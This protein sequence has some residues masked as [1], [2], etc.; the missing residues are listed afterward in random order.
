MNK[1]SI[2]KIFKSPLDKLFGLIGNELSQTFSNR[3]LEYQVE[4]YKRNYYCKTILH[5]STPKALPEFYEPLYI[6]KPRSDNRIETTSTTKLFENRN[7][8]TLIGNAGSGKST[9][10]KYLF[11]NCFKEKYKIPIK[12]ELRYLNEHEGRLNDYIFNEIFHFQKLG[13]SDEIIDRMLSSGEFI[14]FFDGYDEISSKIKEKTTKDIDSFVMKYSKNN[15]I[16]T[17]RPYTNIETL[18]LFENYQVSE[19]N[20]EEIAFFV[21][22]QLPSQEAELAEKIINTIH[23]NENKSY[24]AYLSNPLLLSMFVLTYQSYSNVPQKRSD[25]YEQVFNALFSSHDS[26]SKLGFEHEKLSGL[27]KEQFEEVLQLFSFLSFFDE[28]FIF[29]R[30]YLFEK[31]TLIKSKKNHLIF[32]NSKIINDLQVAIAIL[33]EE[34]VNY[35]FPHRS[36]QE[37]FAAKYISKLDN[38]NKERIYKKIL[39]HIIGLQ[40]RQFSDRFHFYTLLCEIDEKNVI[41][42]AIIPYL[43]SYK[44]T[45]NTLNPELLHQ[46]FFEIKRLYFSFQNILEISDIIDF[47]VK[48]QKNH[49][50]YLLRNFLLKFIPKMISQGEK[51]SECIEKE[52]KDES[53]I[54][55]MI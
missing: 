42:Y 35:T 21:K 14:F 23:K 3:L 29:S 39:S 12:L 26:L 52:Q 27:S 22:K 50:K 7:Y 28:K 9:I 13:F 53:D 30:T 10:V 31:L 45:K 37:Y 2:A 38:K 19:L 54:I 11:T 44:K 49:S 43:F 55:G 34:G 8:I 5:R 41:K 18:P 36:L 24:Q 16:L 20:E 25:F 33:I 15:Y 48:I 1:S 17:S 32:D 47:E 4:E 6:L 46:I 40:T 51:M